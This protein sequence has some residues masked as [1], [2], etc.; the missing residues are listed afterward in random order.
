[1]KLAMLMLCHKNPEQI[2]MLTH[3]M[4]NPDIDFYIHVDKK[5]DISREL[6]TDD[7]VHLLP[8]KLRVDCK[9]A[10]FSLVQAELNL[11]SYAAK[12]RSYDFFWFCSGQDY[13]IKSTS[14]ILNYFENHKHNNFLDLRVSQNWGVHNN[15]DKRNEIYYPFFLFGRSKGKRLLK[16]LY[17]EITGGYNKTFRPFKRFCPFNSY[18]GS[19]WCCLSDETVNWIF[20]YLQNNHNY[21][22]YFM[23]CSTPDESFFQ[24]LVMNSPYKDKREDYLHYVDWSEGKTSPKIL[25]IEDIEELKHSDKLMARKFDIALDERVVEELLA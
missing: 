22:S 20:E 13:P 4:K 15:L 8:D 6:V 17:V 23:H 3:Q 11:L 24:T 25:T 1:M 2:N 10:T 14:Y 16:R 18:F 9:W 19:Q 5:S 7:Q 12:R 21:V